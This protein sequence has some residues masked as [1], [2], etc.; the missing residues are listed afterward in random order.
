MDAS[1]NNEQDSFTSD[2]SE[3]VYT[4]D[5]IQEQNSFHPNSSKAVKS[6]L[7]EFD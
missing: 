1:F 2:H 5:Y 6:N 4:M 7:S 3:S